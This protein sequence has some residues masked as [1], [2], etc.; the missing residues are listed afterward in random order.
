M[1]HLF[2]LAEKSLG[3]S[4]STEA[5]ERF[6]QYCE[7]LLE[8]NKVMNLTAITEPELVYLKHFIDS[9][10]VLTADNLSGKKIIDVGCGAGFPGLPIKI[11]DPSVSL[12]LLDS[13]GKRISFLSSLTDSLGL[14][15]VT[16]IHARA[17]EEA[18]KSDMREQF[19]F[20]VS[21]AV[22]SLPM[23]C[24]LCL[25]FVKIGGS[26]I[27]M[28]SQDYKE[29]LEQAQSAIS[30][31]G[32][33]VDEI[34]EYSLPGSDITHILIVIKKESE[35]PANYPRRFAKIQKKPL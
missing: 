10:A 35:T 5:R 21:R 30:T 18:L 1:T 34:K 19:D 4:F 31:L 3:I 17:E 20:A 12:T 33:K 29:E 16:C 25:P 14:E 32:A 22:A 9:A 6:S 11:C 27:A 24:E 15:D 13:L 2:D 28:K 7:S 23:L 8:T 26:F